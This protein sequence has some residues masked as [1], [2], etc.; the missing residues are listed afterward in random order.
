MTDEKRDRDWTARM[1]QLRSE[2]LAWR[3]AH[4]GATIDDIVARITPGRREMMGQ[5]VEEMVR[6]ESEEAEPEIPCPVC[7]EAAGFRGCQ[8]RQVIHFEGDS[9]LRRRYYYCPRC[10]RGFFPLG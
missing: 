2:L 5:L 8:T 4:L 1:E 7:G 10:E 6:V 3:K 9:T